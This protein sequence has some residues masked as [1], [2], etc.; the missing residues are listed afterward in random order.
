MIQPEPRALA[1]FPVLHQKTIV[2]A[3]AQ[4]LDCTLTSGGQ[5]QRWAATET[6]G[7]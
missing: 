5:Q 3:N 6:N 1:V 7:F 4:G 2:A